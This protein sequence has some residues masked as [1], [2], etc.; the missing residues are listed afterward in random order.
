MAF[1]AQGKQAIRLDALCLASIVFLSALPYVARLGFYSDDWAILGGSHGEAIAGEL[2]LSSALD[3]FG[4][5]PL[6]AGS[7]A[8]AVRGGICRARP[9]DL[10]KHSSDKG[11]KFSVH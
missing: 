8:G 9:A 6:Q 10:T 4:A 3:G 11:A 2:G 7:M 1:P 5:R